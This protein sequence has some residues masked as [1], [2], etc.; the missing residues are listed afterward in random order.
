MA[1]RANLVLVRC[2][3]TRAPRHAIRVDAP[4]R[5]RERL[6]REPLGSPLQTI[7]AT[8]NPRTPRLQQPS[9]LL[10]SSRTSYS[11]NR[12]TSYCAVVEVDAQEPRSRLRHGHRVS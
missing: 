5:P 2:P 11:S 8:D 10:E 7:P 4:P 3:P 1:T 9:E 6:P 12:E